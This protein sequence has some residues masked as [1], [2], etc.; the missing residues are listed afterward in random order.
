MGG[1]KLAPVHR[2]VP[3]LDCFLFVLTFFSIVP[4]FHAVTSLDGGKKCVR[5]L[6]FLLL[7]EIV[8]C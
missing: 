4:L 3:S 7:I 2:P 1:G 8:F 6:F 5:P